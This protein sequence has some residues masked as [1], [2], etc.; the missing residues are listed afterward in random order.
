M[1]A[2]LPQMCRLLKCSAVCRLWF[3]HWFR[4]TVNVMTTNKHVRK[5]EK[6]KVL[7]IHNNTWSLFMFYLHSPAAATDWQRE[8]LIELLCCC[9]G[10][11]PFSPPTSVSYNKRS[12]PP[13]PHMELSGSAQLAL[14][15]WMPTLLLWGQTASGSQVKTGVAD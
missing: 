7:C 10:G 13:L 4:P 12:E 1:I 8:G 9:C 5:R 11:D 15:T 3:H 6:T 2:A 14:W